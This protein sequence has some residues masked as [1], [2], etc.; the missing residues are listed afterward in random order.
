M[1]FPLLLMVLVASAGLA[2]RQTPGPA[3][4]FTMLR[5][6]VVAAD[7]LA[8]APSADRMTVAERQKVIRDL[9]LVERPRP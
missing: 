1:A 2:G 7:L 3:P 5:G 9:R 8:T 6:R 4:A